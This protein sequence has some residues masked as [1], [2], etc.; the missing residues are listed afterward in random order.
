VLISA[1]E[2][3]D[4]RGGRPGL[5]EGP[6]E[7]AVDAPRGSCDSIVHNSGAEIREFTGNRP[8][9]QSLGPVLHLIIHRVVHSCGLAYETLGPQPVE[10]CG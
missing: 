7:A 5:A 4:N 2:T 9:I 6:V 3:V 8:V 1:V 10:T